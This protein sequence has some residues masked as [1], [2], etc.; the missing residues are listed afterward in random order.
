MNPLSLF[1]QAPIPIAHDFKPQLPHWQRR[2]HWLRGH[3]EGT[4]YGHNRKKRR[5]RGGKR[6]YNPMVRAPR[7][8]CR[9]IHRTVRRKGSMK[10][11]TPIELN[12]YDIASLDA[13]S[14][15]GNGAM[16]VQAFCSD[17][18][19]A[20][21]VSVNIP[22][23][24][25]RLADGEFFVKAWSE[26]E[27][28]VSRLIAQGVIVLTDKPAARSGFVSARIGKLDLAKLEG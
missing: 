7:D 9:L 5:N 4:N 23:E 26:N 22:E 21:T 20:C 19:D 11:K 10:Q 13:S 12:G 17:G 2:Q 1:F 18:E 6:Y 24:T 14:K 27:L 8:G 15:Y 16:A 3:G 25:H 28:P